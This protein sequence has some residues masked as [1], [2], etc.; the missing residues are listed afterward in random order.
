MKKK[1]TMNFRR[2]EDVLNFLKESDWNSISQHNNI[3]EVAL[4]PENI[5]NIFDRITKNTNSPLIYESGCGGGITTAQICKY[6]SEKEIK[7]YKLI[8]HDVNEG[9]VKH[10]NKRFSQDDRIIAEL[11]SGSDYSDIPNNSIDGIFSFNTIIPFLGMY[12]TK[13]K[14][15][16]QHEDYLKETSRILKEEKPLVLTYLRAPLVLVKDS[17][18]KDIPFQIKVYNEHDSIKPFLKLLEFVKPINNF[19]YLEELLQK[20]YTIKGPR[21]DP[22][23]DLNSFK[24]F[25]KKGK[26]FAPEDWLS[27]IGYKFVEPSTFTK[28]YR[29]SYKIINDFPD[30]RF[31]SNYSL[32]KEGREI[33]LYLKA[34][35][36]KQKNEINFQK[37]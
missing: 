37:I 33:L 35:L 1:Q 22:A 23:K 8:A 7:N 13:K 6:L 5:K 28:G 26:E 27:S 9:L 18:I 24:A 2:I 17:K 12:Y 10:A 36:P 25:L 14:D 20:G 29:I 32:V 16:S 30:E 4:P 19:S 21:K 3:L 31:N 34:E 15:C 11:R